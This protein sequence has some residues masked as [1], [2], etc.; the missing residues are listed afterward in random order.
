MTNGVAQLSGLAARCCFNVDDLCKYLANGV[1]LVPVGIVFLEA[2]GVAD[3]PD[4][5][6]N[7]IVF[8]V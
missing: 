5:V 1:L 6:A 8:L 2:S 7:A 4:V 3:I